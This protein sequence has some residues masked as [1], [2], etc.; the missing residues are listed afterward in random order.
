LNPNLDTFV[1]HYW[2]LILTP[3]RLCGFQL[4]WGANFLLKNNLDPVSIAGIRAF[5]HAAFK[6]SSR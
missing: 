6:G 1:E 3:N 4:G 5:L 2:T